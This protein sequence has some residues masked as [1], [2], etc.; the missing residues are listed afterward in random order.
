[1]EP[2][3]FEPLHSPV[4]PQAWRNHDLL[5]AKETGDA[6]FHAMDWDAVPKVDYASSQ[7]R[8]LAIPEP[9]RVLEDVHEFV[10]ADY[11]GPAP[12]DASA[13]LAPE[14]MPVEAPSALSQDA[15]TAEDLTAEAPATSDAEPFELASEPE[16][17]EDASALD[18]D[19][20]DWPEEGPA[21]W[22]ADEESVPE[23]VTTLD[24]AALAE[25]C[26]EAYQRGLADGRAEAEKEAAAAIAQALDGAQAQAQELQAEALLQQHKE[27][28]DLMQPDLALL[29]EVTQKLEAWTENPKQLFEPLKRLAVHI[30]EQLVLAELNTS[31][32]A[33]ERLVQRCLDELNL[34][35]SQVV[36]VELNPQDKARLQ[37]VANDMLSQVQLQAIPSLQPGS[38]RVIVNDTQVEDLVEHR[39]EALAHG[40]LG[41]PEAWREKSPFFR[42]PLAQRESEVQDVSQRPA[43]PDI[44]PDEVLDA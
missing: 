15:E 18:A 6:A 25:A 13:S 41:Q 9:A 36:T 21:A 34:H 1:V 17:A 42:Q 20:S 10:M 32:A 22:S 4:P 39:L 2:I 16:T 27:L 5:V 19:A 11:G 44:S 7:F 14:P 37:D 23:E 31:G 8:Q 40:L 28:T 43:L 29:R 24:S 12:Q 30:A 38:V 33:I 3:L 35:G 26:E